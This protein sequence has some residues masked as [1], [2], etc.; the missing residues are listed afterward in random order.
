[1][2]NNKVHPGEVKLLTSFFGPLGK[3]YFY[4]LFRG[5]QDKDI[6]A[7]G[8]CEKYLDAFFFQRIKDQYPYLTPGQEV[9]FYRSQLGRA[10]KVIKYLIGFLALPKE[11]VLRNEIAVFPDSPTQRLKQIADVNVDNNLR[12]E[13]ARQ[14]I[15]AYLASPLD[16]RAASEK[17]QTRLFDFQD[18]LDKKLFIGKTG[19]TEKRT[20]FS[21]HD[22]HT[23]TTINYSL[24]SHKKIK[25]KYGAHL[26]KET[27]DVRTTSINRTEVFTNM[28]HKGENE[29]IIKS[30][31]KAVINHEPINILDSV[32]DS[33]GMKFAIMGNEKVRDEFI[34][35]FEELIKTYKDFDRIEIDDIS[36]VGRG[37]N[38][39]SF[40]RRRQIYLKG[41]SIPIEI[42]FYSTAEYLD[43][44]YEVGREFKG[45]A[46]D[47]YNMR[48]MGAAA[49]I[50]FMQ[51]IYGVD[52]QPF[53]NH[54]LET[55]A[56]ELLYK[57][58][59]DENGNYC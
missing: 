18:F 23:N 13:T 27:L 32:K 25:K 6:L 12:Y 49:K 9:E 52:I 54:R 40:K 3:K 38:K 17:I 33:I 15:L 20:I 30:I 46:H 48:R 22:N 34:Y 11:F 29:S 5:K 2:F 16:E 31:M 19:Q 58:T 59:I 14:M 50:L 10:N 44:E 57:N 21:Q 37:Q 8:N 41:L 42:I 56:D 1:M 26:K 4:N 43:S 36:G 28:R 24:D 53:I 45:K 35:E 39:S 47:L 7:D 51:E 55:I